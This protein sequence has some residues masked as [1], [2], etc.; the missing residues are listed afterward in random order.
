MSELVERAIQDAKTAQEAD[1]IL[2][3]AE[4]AVPPA[5]DRIRRLLRPDAFTKRATPFQVR[6]T[7]EKIMEKLVRL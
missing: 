3:R 5:Q 1:K 6:E 2:K 4:A 7:L